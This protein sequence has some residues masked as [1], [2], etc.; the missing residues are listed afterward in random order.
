MWAYCDTSALVKRYV[1]ELGR[2][3][4]MRLLR[5]YDC[6]TSAISLVELKSALRRRVAAR[7][8]AGARVPELLTHVVE[9]RSYWTLIEVGAEV[10]RGAEALLS[11][12][13]VGTMGGIHVASAQ[14][15]ASR[16][17]AGH[18]TIVTAD[19]RQGEVASA[20]GLATRVIVSPR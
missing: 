8:V 1:D 3:E 15:L 9:D 19:E 4:L 20:I 16:V 6:V 18:V 5:R 14:L 17:S 11:I 12:H 13:A 10:L 2:R 7:D